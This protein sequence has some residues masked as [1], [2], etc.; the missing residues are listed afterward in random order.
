MSSSSSPPSERT[1]ADY[2][3]QHDEECDSRRCACCGR[4]ALHEDTAFNKCEGVFH[5]RPCSCGLDA[6]L[7]AS[8]RVRDA[9]KDFTHRLTEYGNEPTAERYIAAKAA[10]D[11][12]VELRSAP[13]QEPTEKE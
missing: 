1:L 3:P 8:Y 9:E 2:R 5:P 13:H 7:S 10:H 12:V 11:R 6:L 4:F